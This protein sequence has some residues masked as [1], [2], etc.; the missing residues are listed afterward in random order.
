[1]ADGVF[2]SMR[3]LDGMSVAAGVAGIRVRTAALIVAIATLGLLLM[4]VSSA[5]AAI[6]HPFVSSFGALTNPQAVSVDQGSG[7]VYVI[8]V[9]TESVLKFDSSGVAANFSALGTNVLDGASGPDLTPQ[10]SF[11]FDANSAAQLAVDDSG[12]PTD[13][14]LYVTNSLTE[15]VDVFDATGTYVGELDGSAATPQSGGEACGVATDASGNVYAA[16]FSGH[17]DKYTPV[18]AT[19]SHDTF[20]GQLENLANPCNIAVDSLGHIDV[21]TWSTGPLTQYDASQLNQDAPT[22]TVI[23]T[24]SL[25]VA[26]DPATNDVYVDE[27]DHISQFDAAGS[28]VGRSGAGHLAGSSFGV[29]INAAS[30]DLYASDAD[31]GSIAHF[32]APVDITPPTVAID[33]PSGVTSSHADLSGTV[34]P[35]GTSPS[36]DTAWHFEYSIDGGSTWTSTSG[37]DAGTGTT[38]VPVSDQVNGL[39]P[40]QPTLVRLVAINA[41]GTTTSGNQSFTTDAV[42]PDV[43]T[44]GSRDLQPKHA[45]LVGFVN[46]RHSSTTYYFDYGPT[47][48]YGS[49]APATHDADAG[50]GT[51]A[52]PVTQDVDGL[53]A[54]M[55]Y[56]Y[57]IV[58]HNQAGTTTGSDRTFTTLEP[59]AP[60]VAQDGIPGTGFLPDNRGWELVSPADKNGSDVLVDSARVRAQS[61]P[62]PGLPTA[63]MFSSLGGFGNVLGSGVAGDYMSQRDGTA[64]TQGWSTHGITPRQDPLT[65][66]ADFQGFDPL[67]EGEFSADLSTGVFRA[68]SSLTQDP[69]VANVENLYTRTDLRTP[70]AGAYQLLS[71]CPGCGATPLP[72]MDSGFQK[73]SLV[74]ASA[75]FSHVVFESVEPLTPNATANAGSDIPNLY[76]STNGVLRLVGV[77]SDGT[78]APSSQAGQGLSQ[79]VPHYAPHAISR[80][81]ARIEFTDNSATRN[82][83]GALYQRVNGSSTIALSA[84]ERTDC[85]DHDPCSGTPE[86][87]PQGATPAKYWN[88][89]ADGSRIFFTSPEKLTDDDT[90]SSAD[91]YMY[92]TSGAPGHHLTRVSVDGE[93]SDAVDD[94][95]GVIGVS[96]DGASVYFVAHGQLVAGAPRLGSADGIYLSRAG[97]LSYIGQLT[98]SGDLH[99]D[100]PDNYAIDGNR[101]AARVSPNGD[102]LLF[103]ATSDP[104]T[105]VPN[106]GCGGGCA[107]LYVFSASNGGRLACASCAPGVPMTTPASDMDRTGTGGSSTGSHLSHALSDDGAHVFFTTAAPLVSGD[108]NGKSDAYEYDIRSGTAHLLSSGKDPSDSYFMDASADGSD[109]Y[110]VTRQQLVGWDRDQS[111]DLYDARIDGGFPNPPTATPGC[112]G[113][114]CQGAVTNSPSA[115]SPSSTSFTGPGNVHPSKP[116]PK[117]KKAKPVKCKRGFVRKKVKGKV[118]CVKRP[119]KHVAKKSARRSHRSAK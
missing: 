41:G 32:G 44:G 99:N 79:S 56:H 34:N 61:V 81:G 77:L 105:G 62:S 96:D 8:D 11:A 112:S 45:L 60:P 106:G 94:V 117:A 27:G 20:A 100:L 98:S 111:I 57:R 36:S 19:P 102:H 42:A 47:T 107:E 33:A 35:Q 91:L 63:A 90:N 82:A 86:I 74:G 9:G 92:D 108:V 84:S 65:F 109:A 48:A 55:T 73:P 97:G 25:A 115:Q 76:E 21:S 26:I 37:G 69:A 85:A 88:A 13:G 80:D 38:D 72:A 95:L 116:K 78:A 113:D 103:T 7:D 54:G 110:F 17:V 24:T 83:S 46:P 15:A 51:A 4:G 67:Y 1:M 43:T 93:P 6:V 2:V 114:T 75:D 18:D 70:G 31:T 23:D 119:K 3:G 104:T 40:N 53:Q 89:S 29:A 50:S 49:S 71:S 30:G 101:L 64:G 39:Q 22:G 28:P 68:W 58:A 66:N 87:D 118:R 52:A 59:P 5:P 14:Y 12:G 10:G 16:H